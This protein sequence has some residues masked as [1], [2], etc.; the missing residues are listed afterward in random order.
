MSRFNLTKYTILFLTLLISSCS[1]LKIP[2]D[3]PKVEVVALKAV[4]SSQAIPN[5]L[6]TLRVINPNAQAIN[7]RG[8][9]YTVNIEGYDLLSGVSND[10][11]TVEGYAETNIELTAKASLISGIRLM[12]KLV[13]KPLDALN[14]TV[15][16]KIDSGSIMGAIKVSHD[17]ILSL[18]NTGTTTKQR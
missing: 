3:Q 18:D 12:G 6:I 10:I 16:A 8:I 5:F 14:Y 1:S 13:Q 17:G 9:F 11:P 4:P 2:F 7:I 15:T